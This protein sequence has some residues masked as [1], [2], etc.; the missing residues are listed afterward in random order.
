MSKW[1]KL[2]LSMVACFLISLMFC[3]HITTPPQP[4]KFALVGGGT[5]AFLQLVVGGI[6]IKV[7]RKEN[8]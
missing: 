6:S 1:V 4:W 8:L 3:R 2:V 7:W 5:A